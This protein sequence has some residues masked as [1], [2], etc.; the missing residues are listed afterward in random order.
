M[1]ERRG[2]DRRPTSSRSTWATARLDRDE[3]DWLHERRLRDLELADRDPRALRAHRRRRSCATGRRATACGVIPYAADCGRFRPIRPSA[4]TRPA[5]SSSPAGSPSA[6]GSSTC[7][8]PGGGSAGRA[9]GSSSWG[10]CPASPVRS[11]PYLDEVEL[12]GR[13]AACRDARPAWPRPT[14]SCS[15]RSSRA[16]PS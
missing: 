5:R 6:R 13:V 14:S 15:R 11:G 12:L 7:S 4:R 3:L 10:R 1:L 8:R 9:G 16:R 2:R